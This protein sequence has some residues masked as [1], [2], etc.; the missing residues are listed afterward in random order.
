[1]LLFLISTAYSSVT[2]SHNHYDD[3]PNYSQRDPLEKINR[4]FFSVNYLLD[5]LVL[6]PIAK[7][8]K[9]VL[10]RNIQKGINNVYNNFGEIRNLV[11]FGLQADGKN[12]L[13]S[14]KRLLVN[15]TVGILGII[16][17]A[18][19]FGYKH[20][21]NSFGR[22]IFSWTGIDGIYLELPILGSTTFS[23]AIGYLVDLPLLPEFYIDKSSK[24]YV[25]NTIKA[26]NSRSKLIGVDKLMYGDKYSLKRNIYLNERYVELHPDE[27]MED[28]F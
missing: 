25:A 9:T 17:I 20:H 11:N 27:A 6:R 15:S 12:M 26:V 10:P 22:T 14:S 1:M 8:Y 18:E 19:D 24:Y 21:Y 4:F 16:D 3:S 2:Y 23:S 28:D 7:T 13:N 5:Q